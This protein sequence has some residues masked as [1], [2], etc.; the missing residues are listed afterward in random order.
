[1]NAFAQRLKDRSG[2]P[3]LGTWLSSASPIYAEAAGHAGF[4]WA[5]VDMEHSPLDMATLV[6]S[7]Q[8]TLGS[9]MLPIVRV[10]WNDSVTVKRVLDAGA[11]TVLFPFVQDEQEA[12][13]AVAATRYPPHGV[14]GMAGMNRG[15]RFGTA[16]DHF[17]SANDRMGV[18]VQLETPQAMARLEA[19]AQVP[20]VDAI[21]IGPADLSGTMGLP[22]QLTHP[23]VVAAMVE[24]AARAH[25]VGSRIGTV[26]GTVEWVA[27]FRDAGYDFV[28]LASDLGLFMRAATAALKTLRSDDVKVDG[29]Y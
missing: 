7:L 17:V 1:M 21:F 19:I 4:D 15:S 27:R 29:G 22:G 20:G 16:P 5:V 24:A 25:A 9:S 23:D 3:L 6:Q 2:G 10:P 11:E 13:Q 12:A 28:G 14:R 8:A 26:M 18:I